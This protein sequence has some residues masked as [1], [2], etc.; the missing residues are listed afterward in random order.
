MGCNSLPIIAGI[1]DETK[2][3]LPVPRSILITGGGGFVAGSVIAQAPPGATVHV[4]SRSQPMLQRPGLT[5]HHQDPLDQ[6]GMERLMQTAKPEVV[7][8]TA[9]IA[10]IDYCETHQEEARA[11]NT[12]WP[13]RLGRL[14]EE[15][16]RRF[17][18]LSTD[19][20]F[21]GE[22]GL[23]TEE[24]PAVPVNYYGRT[25]VAAEEATAA[26]STPWVVARVSIV[27]GLPIL[28]A[29]NAFLARMLPELEQGKTIGVPPEEVRTPIDVITLG[30]ALLEL[31]G[32]DF[33]GHLHLSG[34]DAL[35]RFEFVQRIAVALGYP[36]E[37]VEPNDPTHIPGRAPRPRDASLA[38][39]K[40]R[41][42]L[43]T[44]LCGVAEGTRRIMAFRD[45]H[46]AQT[47]QGH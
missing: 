14:A 11:V 4:L 32:N 27:M 13:R 37:Q 43:K 30:Q 28:G 31:C 22:K 36:A 35:N 3:D 2:K 38:N 9:A 42:L 26:L 5:W 1:P 47:A 16:G 40:A 10:G 39:T 41:N 29:G 23:Y 44:P 45:Q 17:I 19:N 24:D 33:T 12:D 46:P 20:V 21:G 25:K 18:F 15:H 7:L 6:T 8:H 34:N